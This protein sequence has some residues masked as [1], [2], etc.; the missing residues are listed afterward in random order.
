MKETKAKWIFAAFF[1]GAAILYIQM[2]LYAVHQVWGLRAGFNLFE[3]CLLAVQILGI[4]VIGYALNGL[5]LCTFAISAGYPAWQLILSARVMRRIRRLEDP[6]RTRAI[7]QTTGNPRITVISGARPAALTLGFLRPR[8]ILSTGLLEMLET[9]ELHAV[10]AH[11]RCHQLRRDPLRS[12]VHS[13]LAAVFWYMPIYRWMCQRHKM[14]AELAADRHALVQI[15]APEALG[16]ALL[17]MLKAGQSPLPSV[18]CVS[19]AESSINLRILHLLEPDQDVRFGWPAA[20][21]AVSIP[22]FLSAIVVM[23]LA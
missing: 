4:P 14:L 7:R 19:F 12:L 1:A 20:D 18:S 6:E 16:R 15:G 23:A 5:I 8:I 17:K 13:Y 3:I 10:L 21:L 2:A 9:E 22:A 11:E